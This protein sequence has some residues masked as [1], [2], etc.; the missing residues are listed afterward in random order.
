MKTIVRVSKASSTN[1]I[2][3]KSSTLYKWFHIG[4]H[5]EIFVKLGGALYVD[6]D[7]FDLL[8]E[9]NRGKVRTKSAILK[10]AKR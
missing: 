5:T 10:L 2:P 3:L 1:D 7:A 4:K 9:K 8:I 6:L